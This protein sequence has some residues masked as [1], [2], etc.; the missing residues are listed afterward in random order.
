MSGHP[1]RA[2][3][4]GIAHTTH[5]FVMDDAS[6]AVANFVAEF[7]NGNFAVAELCLDLLELEGLPIERG[8]ELLGAL[9]EANLDPEC[10]VRVW[11]RGGPLT[12]IVKMAI[13]FEYPEEAAIVLP[14]YNKFGWTAHR[15][16]AHW[17]QTHPDKPLN[18]WGVK[19]PEFD[20]SRS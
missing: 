13:L 17:G 8:L 7:A 5:W 6:Q 20:P 9:K 19:M 14:V 2:L 16:A 15:I 12:L 4:V 11:A 3:T 10:L 18:T 1:N